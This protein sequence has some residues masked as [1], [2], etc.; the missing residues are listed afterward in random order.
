MA[1]IPTYTLE[2]LA[3]LN[4]PGYKTKGSYLSIFEQENDWQPILSASVFREG[5]EGQGL[6]TLTGV[7]RDKT[8]PDGRASTHDAV[9]STPT[10]QLAKGSRHIKN[11]VKL[12]ELRGQ[13]AAQPDQVALAE[14]APLTSEFCTVVSFA[15]NPE[16]FGVMGGNLAYFTDRLIDYKLDCQLAIEANKLGI[17][18]G[19][20]SL[21]S[22]H[23]GF[24]AVG[25]N[26]DRYEPLLELAAAVMLTDEAA[27]LIPEEN[28]KYSHLSWVDAGTF[29]ENVEKK[30]A[31]ALAPRAGKAAVWFC[32]Y[33]MC[34]QA[35]SHVVSRDDI[36][37]HLALNAAAN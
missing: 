9:V 1:E 24:S 28:D 16:P 19:R 36:S 21:A 10:M 34:L 11:L 31:F 15:P 17:S 3:N 4:L 27:E 2:E 32:A 12:R 18:L 22:A 6:Q 23:I 29:A 14:D 7:R 37:G 20:V 26:H 30:D 13:F 5:P 25:E 33:G 8:K 35:T